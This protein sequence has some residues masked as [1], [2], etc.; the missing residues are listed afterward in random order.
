M[1]LKPATIAGES[2]PETQQKL[3]AGGAIFN[4]D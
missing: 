2:K 3:T 4:A 1:P